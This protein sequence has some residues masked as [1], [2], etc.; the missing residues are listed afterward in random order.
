MGC[1][2]DALLRKFGAEPPEEWKGA[3]GMLSAE[4]IRRGMRR[5]VFGWKGGPPNLPDFV[6]LCRTIGDDAPDEGPKPVALPNPN[7][8]NG[9]KWGEVANTHLLAHIAHQAK[10]GVHYA[11]GRD[12]TAGHLG[13]GWKPTRETAEMTAMLV[14]Y[15]NAWARDMREWAVDRETGEVVIPSAAEQKRAWDDCMSRAEA[16]IDQMRRQYAAGAVA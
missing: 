15:K 10:A 6:R 3:I 4:E 5:I 11:A 8:W 1:F 7:A 13:N 9:D 2:G 14:A 16:E 12:R